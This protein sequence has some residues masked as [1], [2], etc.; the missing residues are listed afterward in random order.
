ME[1]R[2]SAGRRWVVKRDMENREK[3]Q[4]RWASRAG[5]P[6]EKN[7]H[8]GLG[9]RSPAGLRGGRLRWWR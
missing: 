5:K 9:C 8:E 2:K 3:R 7:S 1:V 4:K 6:G